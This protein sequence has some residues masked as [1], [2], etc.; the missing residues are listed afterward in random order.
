MQEFAI[1]RTLATEG[2]SD[3]SESTDSP[4]PSSAEVSRIAGILQSEAPSVQPAAIAQ[5]QAQSSAD[6]AKDAVGAAFDESIHVRDAD[7]NPKKTVRGT[8]ALKRG[9][10]AT[11]QS[12]QSSVVGP[13][14]PMQSVAQV[15][16]ATG[17]NAAALLVTTGMTFGGKEWE[18]VLSEEHGID[19]MANL[20]KAFGDYFAAKNMQDIPPGIALSIAVLGYAGPRFFAPQTKARLSAV[21]Q[22]IAPKAA[23]LVGLFTRRKPATQREMDLRPPAPAARHVA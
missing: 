22:W 1:K 13:A 8:W 14:K 12:A 18:P 2:E 6:V 9:R 20:K 7:G 19:E 11:P 4:L 16:R 3:Q 21:K 23:W 15:A 17:E 10:K 5:H